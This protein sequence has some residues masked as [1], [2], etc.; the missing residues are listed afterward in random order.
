MT[1]RCVPTT[2]LVVL[3]AG[4]SCGCV[5]GVEIDPAARQRDEALAKV[6]KLQVENQDL[7]DRVTRLEEQ[8]KDLQ[9]L[10]DKRL[11]KLYTVK[12]ITLGTHT[13]GVNLDGKPGDDAIKVFLEPIDQHGSTIKAS[14]DVTVQLYDLA[15]PEGENLIGEARFGIDEVAKKWYSGFLTYHYSFTCRW[16]SR[17]P[18]HDQ[19]TVRVVFLDYLTGKS[20]TA[21]KLC[22][23]ALPPS[24]Q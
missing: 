24:K 16:K 13:G 10:G 6:R 5:D 4:W 19:V 23:I 12:E 15:A 3:L 1:L 2:G 22:K 8:V 20:F 7:R 14:G 9:K 18:A 21:Q 17:P 11:E